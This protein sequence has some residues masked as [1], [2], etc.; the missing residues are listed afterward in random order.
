VLDQ[1]GVQYPADLGNVGVDHYLGP[2]EEGVLPEFG[3]VG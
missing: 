2:I 1:A 3:E